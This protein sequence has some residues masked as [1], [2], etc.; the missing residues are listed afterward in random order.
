MHHLARDLNP[1]KHTIQEAHDAPWIGARGSNTGPV[2][3]TPVRAIFTDDFN[4][5]G[6]L[7][8]KFKALLTSQFFS[9]NLM[10]TTITWAVEFRWRSILG[11]FLVNSFAEL[12]QKARCPT[13]DFAVKG[14]IIFAYVKCTTFM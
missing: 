13:M 8:W 7:L 1:G 14:V 12:S 4:G 10:I 11:I 6:G 3:E 2:L 5:R 9:L